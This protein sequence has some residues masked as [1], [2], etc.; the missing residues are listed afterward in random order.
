MADFERV[1]DNARVG[2]KPS[3]NYVT[4]LAMLD[5]E[6]RESMTVSHAY[7]G[8]P[9]R[10]AKHYYASVLFT[11]LVSRA[12]SL[13]NLAP[14][15]EWSN[16]I[17]EHWDYASAAGVTRTML[18]I[19]LAFYYLCIDPCDDAEWKCRWGLFNIHDCISRRKLFDAMEDLEQVD[20]FDK[21]AERLRDDLR[22]NSYFQSLPAGEQ[23]K[24]LNG[25]HAYLEP[26][27]VIAEKSGMEKKFFRTQYVFLSSHVHALPMSFYRISPG[28]PDRGRGLPSRVE[29]EYTVMCLSLAAALL[30]MTREDF[31]KLFD[32]IEP[33]ALEHP[34]GDANIELAPS[35]EQQSLMAIGES[36]RLME[37][38]LLFVDATRKTEDLFEIVYRH[39]STGTVVLVR[40]VS[41]IQGSSLYDM[42]PMFWTV[43]VNGKPVPESVL[44]ASAPGDHTFKVDPHSMSIDFKF[45]TD[46]SSATRS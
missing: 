44:L 12:V 5:S 43:R 33:R 29:E 45:A 6:V 1:L 37:T 36:I 15:S 3:E 4:C 34:R 25:Q 14:H 16:K 40:R 42:D 20:A 9:S 10:S 8:I 13:V 26:L 24:F 18:E 27:E 11:T 2:Q 32:G 30:A 46:T 19:R 17:I 39:K 28:N 38:E 23:R 21:H 35:V 7:G 41:E 31:A 22:A